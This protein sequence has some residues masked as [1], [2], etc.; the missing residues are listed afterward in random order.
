[1]LLWNWENPRI[2][3]SSVLSAR[4]AAPALA[5][6]LAFWTCPFTTSFDSSQGCTAWASG[7]P[8]LDRLP[9]T[10]TAARQRL[11]SR[12]PD[13]LLDDLSTCHFHLVTFL[14]HLVLSNWTRIRPLSLP[15]SCAAGHSASR[16]HLG[17]LD[18]CR[19]RLYHGGTL[20][21]LAICPPSIS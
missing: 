11:P 7:V 1:V 2:R 16:K 18:P 4:I 5:S 15:A 13:A 12:L 9:A 20:A 19:D 10:A 3:S 8:P 21:L 17:N 14:P 6:A